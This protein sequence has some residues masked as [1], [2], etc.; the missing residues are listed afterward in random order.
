MDQIEVG[1]LCTIGITSIGMLAC[2]IYKTH[3]E[4]RRTTLQQ[5]ANIHSHPEQEEDIVVGTA[6]TSEQ[7][8]NN[9]VLVAIDSDDDSPRLAQIVPC[10][11]IISKEIPNAELV[12]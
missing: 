2:L 3:C 1:V 10:R 11:G 6:V 4:K 7:H 5:N 8:N 12:Q 9:V